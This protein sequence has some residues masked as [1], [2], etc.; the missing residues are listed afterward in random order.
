MK[1]TTILAFT[2]VELLVVIAIIGVLIALLLPAVQAAREAA[3]RM[4]CA[5]Q[6][7]QLSL[8][9]HNFHD[10]NNRFPASS[11]DPI[12]VSKNIN[13]GGALTLLLPFTEQS[14]LYSNLVFSSAPLFQKAEGR[15]RIGTLL[16]PSDSNINLWNDTMCAHTS[17][18]GSRGD[19]AGHD[20]GAGMDATNPDDQVPMSR[21]WLQAGRFL[22][23]FERVTDGTSNSVM[24]SE[25]I[26]GDG[27][28]GNIGGNYKMR[29]ATTALAHY[30]QIPQNCLN[31]RGPGNEFNDSSQNC[32]ND[33]DHNLGRR[34]WDNYVHPVYFYTLLPPNSPS[35][36]SGYVYIWVSASSNH[37]GGVNI[38]L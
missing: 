10:A 29:I 7:K 3:R 21:S 36:H 15:V 19:L 27:Q 25:G 9:V 12:Y 17:Y 16:C 32:L 35:C 20:S 26:I 2:L 8:A 1:K 6:I 30:N 13:R 28:G 5:N 18:R 24:F 37:P 4:Q 33:A 38:S 23:G 14:T 34:A 31:L 22:G 11:F